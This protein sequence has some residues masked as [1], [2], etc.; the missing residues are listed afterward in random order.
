MSDL[1]INNTLKPAEAHLNGGKGR[2]YG[3]YALIFLRPHIAVIDCILNV[4]G[5]TV[6]RLQKA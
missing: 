3:T 1:H 2:G 5:V 4:C 6:G